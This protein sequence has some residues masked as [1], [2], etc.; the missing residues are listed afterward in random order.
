M[1]V[2]SLSMR[3][4][5]KAENFPSIPSAIAAAFDVNSRSASSSALLAA[6]WAYTSASSWSRG[7]AEIDEFE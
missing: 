6:T 5:C 3:R 2:A 4:R 7:A 1:L